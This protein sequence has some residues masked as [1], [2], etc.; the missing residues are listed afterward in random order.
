MS[1]ALARRLLFALPAETAHDVTLHGLQLLQRAGLGHLF[2]ARDTGT[3]V[4]CCGLEFPNAVG[5]AAGLDKNADYVDSLGAL[6][7]G[8]VEVGTLT[9]RPQPGNPRPRL[10]R[11][12]RHE[13][14]INRMGFNNKG[15]DH[16]VAQLRKRRFA[17]I[18]GVNIGKNRDTPL[19]RALDD[20]A[21]CLGRV[22]PVA[23]YVTINISSPNTPGLRELQ[24]EA[25]LDALLGP[26]K[27]QVLRL[28]A[29]AGRRVP[30]M[31]KIAPDLDAAALDVIAHAILRHGVDGLIA[32][33][34]TADHSAVAAARHGD[35]AGGLSGTPLAAT[36]TAILQE[37]ASRLDGRVPLIGVGGIR[38]GDSA[39]ARIAAGATLVQIYTGLIY[40]GP[41]L[42][43]ELVRAMRE[44]A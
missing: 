4:Q 42:V 20:Y 19:D 24:G 5:L 12:P 31:V 8:S 6:G 38:D 32:T 44:S 14:L 16:A 9:P 21:D 27:D 22:H 35:E 17:G 29:A 1:Y 25:A 39:R 40:R 43:D 23:D 15:V 2:T 30:L 33:N 13:A 3:S 10:F 37:L 18:V 28:D 34:T 26:L 11:L 36:S 7:F 41:A